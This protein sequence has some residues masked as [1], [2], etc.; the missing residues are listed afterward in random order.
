[1]GGGGLPCDH[2]PMLLFLS[3]FHPSA[4]PHPPFSYFP[5]S[6]LLCVLVYLVSTAFMASPVLLR[7]AKPL[8]FPLS[9]AR[10]SVLSLF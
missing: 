3:F 1:M 7:D 2:W 9:C 6:Y 10:L 5:S 4:L 8:G